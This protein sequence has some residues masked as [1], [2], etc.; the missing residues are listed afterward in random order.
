[1]N[2]PR[3]NFG[4]TRSKDKPYAVYVSP[5]GW[6]WKVLKTY[7]HSTAEA[8]DPYARW[9]VAATS[10]MMPDGSYEMGDTYA[11][12]VIE[13]GALVDCDPSWMDEYSAHTALH[14]PLLQD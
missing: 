9:F 11:C 7:K 14:D 12:E 13:Q 5:Y 2:M 1:M 3:T 10:P 6:T 4:K 8:K